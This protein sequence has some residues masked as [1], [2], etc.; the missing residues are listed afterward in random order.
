MRIQVHPRL[1]HTEQ[2]YES[3]PKSPTFSAVIRYEPI[4][5][6]LDLHQ[7]AL[8]VYLQ[9]ADPIVPADRLGRAIRVLHKCLPTQNSHITAFATDCST[10]NAPVSE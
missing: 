1:H 3:Q 10:D 7:L 6:I 8:A 5:Q 4:V 9:F 2:T